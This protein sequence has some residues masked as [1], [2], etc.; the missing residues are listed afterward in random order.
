MKLSS[1]FLVVLA[2]FFANAS[3]IH[4]GSTS[5]TSRHHHL[6][7]RVSPGRSLS[8]R[9]R[10]HP[11]NHTNTN[12]DTNSNSNNFA[13]SVPSPPVAPP[14]GQPQL[15]QQQYQEPPQQAP[16]APIPLPPAGNYGSGVIQ[17]V[18][19]NCG[20]NGAT[21]ETT[22]ST[23]PN[24]SIYWLNCGIDGGGWQP[25][26]FTI[27]DLKIRSLSDVINS[28]N[29]PFES[30]RNFLQHFEVN[31]AQYGIPS[32]IIASIAMQE[33]S[34]NPDTVGGGGE[35]GIMQI[36]H[37]KCINPPNNNCRDPA[38]NIATGT[39]FLAGLLAENNGDILT[40]LGRYNGWYRGMTI[41]DATAAAN[42]SCCRCQ[43]NLDY[44][45]Q[46]LNAWFQGIDAY[47]RN[48]RVGVYNNL[49][50]CG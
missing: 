40:S 2:S 17:V 19:S 1:V 44:L 26:F 37:D 34:C 8:K 48:H 41:A 10:N 42:T 18:D 3:V 4:I 50:V 11:I 33:S 9:C 20:P 16:P 12:T 45:A 22:S 15:E 29:S 31:A 30:C 43:K 5:L 14:Q 23:G 13:P 28:G 7:R 49:D 38:Y 35:Q 6:A 39:A 21:P 47:D 25:P 36:T 46:N 27:K 32:I 24:G